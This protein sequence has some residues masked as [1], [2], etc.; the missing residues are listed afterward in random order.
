MY[1]QG[2][3]HRQSDKRG[4]PEPAGQHQ[5]ARGRRW[6]I[7]ES[8]NKPKQGR[9]DNEHKPGHQNR[10]QQSWFEMQTVHLTKN[11]CRKSD[12]HDEGVQCCV[13]IVWYSSKL[14]QGKTDR[15]AQD[16]QNNILHFFASPRVCQ[17]EPL[18]NLWRLL[19]AG[20]FVL[21]PGRPALL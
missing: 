19:A 17:K 14:S 18:L 20:V 5:G 16:E 6:Q 3:D 9:S 13:C 12:V 10:Q 15:Q 7:E 1:K 11:K 8:S 2:L 4:A 21:I